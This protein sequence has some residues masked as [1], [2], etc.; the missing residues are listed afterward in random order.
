MGVPP[1]KGRLTIYGGR[2]DRYDLSSLIKI[3]SCGDI[4]MKI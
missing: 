1:K 2:V 4:E 3:L